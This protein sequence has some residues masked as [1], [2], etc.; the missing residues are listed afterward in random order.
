MLLFTVK[1]ETDEFSLYECE[2]F[3]R[4]SIADI[5]QNGKEMHYWVA[6]SSSSTALSQVAL[7][8]QKLPVL[9]AAC[10]RNFST[11]NK[12]VANDLN[13]LKGGIVDDISFINLSNNLDERN[14]EQTEWWPKPAKS[15]KDSQR[16]ITLQEL[17][18]LGS[19][20]FAQSVTSQLLHCTD[21]VLAIHYCK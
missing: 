5:K 16:N 9:S 2:I 4:S 15:H 12:L 19:N 3:N 17:Y 7:S 21:F 18:F 14:G 20:I 6:K 8:L 1:A 11:L 10:K 13:R